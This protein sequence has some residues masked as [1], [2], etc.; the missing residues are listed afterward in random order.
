MVDCTQEKCAPQLAGDQTNPKDLVGITKPQV[1][2]VPPASIAYQA[3]AMEDGAG[4][5]GAYNWREK[6]VK[7]S[8]YY[9]AALRHLMQWH[10]GEENA[11]DSG[12]PHLAHAIAC[13]GILIDA[14]ETGN[15][16]DDRPTKGAASAV[17]KKWTKSK[18]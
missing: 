4:K 7:A 1:N 12:K 17:I 10:D 9:A 11:D 18:T 8:I 3:L 16:I 6:K 15:L 14:V 2:L 13:I 5:Y